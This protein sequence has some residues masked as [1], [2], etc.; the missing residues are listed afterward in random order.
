MPSKFDSPNGI[1]DRYVNGSDD[2]ISVY[3][4]IY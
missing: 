1:V 2:L 3:E 4:L